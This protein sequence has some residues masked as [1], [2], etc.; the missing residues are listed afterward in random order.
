MTCAH[1]LSFL[2]RCLIKRARL[3]QRLF[4]GFSSRLN[5]HISIIR[6][7]NITY[8]GASV[9][10]QAEGY[11]RVLMKLLPNYNHKIYAYGSQHICDAGICYLNDCLA[12]S[13]NLIFVD[14]FSTGYIQEKN[15]DHV[16][17]CINTLVNKF[18]SVNAFPIFLLLPQPKNM[19]KLYEP[20]KSHLESLNVRYIDLES[21]VGFSPEYVRD[22]IHTTVKG[23]IAYGRAIYGAL[24]QDRILDISKLKDPGK[25]DLSDIKK[26]SLN[27]QIH[28]HLI[29]S[30]S[31][32]V[33][34]FSQTI[35]PFSGYV[36]VNNKV[37][38]IWDRWCHYER[39]AIRM[40]FV[41]DGEVE[42]RVLQYEFDRSDCE[43]QI[44][45]P[46]RRKLVVRDVFFTGSNFRAERADWRDVR[47]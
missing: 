40:G 36:L 46:E 16:I 32:N 43:H 9:T 34:G 21:L 17:L 26:A 19:A 3:N 11:A 42:V 45:W 33:I 20:I 4:S 39:D 12:D 41:L 8:F 25:T 13:P 47:A 1:Q 10:Q 14:W 44:M 29:V 35:G 31:S 23:S 5:F 18:L 15:L 30:G 7:K 24:I 2:A 28:D 27:I 37:V 6:M 38:Q 22:D